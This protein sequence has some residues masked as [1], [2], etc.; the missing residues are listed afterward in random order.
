MII[1]RKTMVLMSKDQSDEDVQ[2]RY[3]LHYNFSAVAGGYDPYLQRKECLVI[4]PKNSYCDILSQDSKDGENNNSLCPAG[5]HIPTAAL[6]YGTFGN[7]LRL[8]W[9][10]LIIFL[11]FR[12]WHM[13]TAGAGG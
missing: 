7:L 11:A 1:I 9:T 12:W 2:K 3:G 6:Q 8:I 13:M 5:W 4:D 10:M